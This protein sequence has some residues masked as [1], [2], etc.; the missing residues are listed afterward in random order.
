MRTIIAG[1]RMCEDYSL[2][3]ASI[4]ELEWPITEIVSGMARGV[5]KL[6]VRWAN[7]TNTPL[8]KYPAEWDKFG[9]SAGYRRNVEMSKNADALLA[10]WDG[11]SKGTK[12]MINIATEA[13]LK[14]KVVQYKRT[15]YPFDKRIEK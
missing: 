7:E 10:I 2:V 9:K 8:K 6:G 1:S 11:A 4:E 13:G 3:K 5:D 12:H 15:G 14:I